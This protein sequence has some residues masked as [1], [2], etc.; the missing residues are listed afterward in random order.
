MIGVIGEDFGF[1]WTDVLG[2]TCVDFLGVTCGVGFLGDGSL[3][4]DLVVV[5]NVF[6]VDE[7]LV[8]MAAKGS[9]VSCGCSR[10]SSS[11][12]DNNS[13]RRDVG[14]TEA[15]ATRDCVISGLPGD[16]SYCLFLVTGG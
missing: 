9:I 10:G 6:F 1:S 8:T 4:A 7:A 16:C 13:T 14:R 15:D 3:L 5:G 2:V 11:D 12:T